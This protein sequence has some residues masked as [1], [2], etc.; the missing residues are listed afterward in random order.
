[1][2]R[3]QRWG[4]LVVSGLALSAALAA[5]ACAPVARETIPSF[6]DSGGQTTAEAIEQLERISGVSVDRL[7]I[8]QAPNAKNSTSAELAVTVADDFVV[9]DPDA[10]VDLLARTAWSVRDG[11]Q[12]TSRLY[13]SVTTDTANSF[14]LGAAAVASGW[15]D[16]SRAFDGGTSRAS[17]TLSS[18]SQ[19]DAG[20]RNL[21]RLG[22]WPGDVPEA[23]SGITREIDGAAA[24]PGSATSDQATTEGE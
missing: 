7:S 3:R 23:S 2:V 24:A 14:D 20:A 6:P 8:S 13:L 10:F 17:I 4:T 5:T 11:Y 19:S 1:M 22:A 15:L 16:T 9:A 18:N 12:P 21:E